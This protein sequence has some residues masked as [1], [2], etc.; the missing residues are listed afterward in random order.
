MQ[1]RGKISAWQ[2]GILLFVLM[3]ANKV[4]ILPSLL[5]EKIKME[6]FFVPIIMFL[7]DFCILIL[8]FF[9]KKKH[10]EEKF[11]DIV[12]TLFGKTFAVFLYVLF[13]AFFMAKTTLLYNVSYIFLRNLIYRDASS[14]MF[15][16]CVLPVV[17]F[18]A[19]SG[20]RP[21]GRTVQIFFPIIFLIVTFCIV[22]GSFGINSNMLLFQTPFSSV[23]SQ[24]FRHIGSFG[25]TLFLFLIM[26]KISVKNGQWKVVFSLEILSMLFVVGINIVFIFSYTYTSFLHPFAIFELMSFVKEYEGLGRIDIISVVLIIIFIY[27]HLS[28]YLKGVL[29]A[30]ESAVT[31]FKANNV[32]II[33]DVLISILSIFVFFNLGRTIIFGE[34]ILPY[35]CFIPLIMLT[36][37]C[38]I[39]LA[40]KRRKNEK[41][42]S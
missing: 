28:I 33:Y 21:L 39:V 17:N 41:I 18:L 40:K 10:P 26:D 2:T 8:F 7:I 19:F 3:F 15:L 37:S 38:V 9:V 30:A 23:L 34:Q 14:L 29:C 35:F 4:M 11:F 22:I 32:I 6:A 27:F 20:L 36:V 12:K 25:D 42:S 31:K 13:I 1:R 16:F 24:S 5:S